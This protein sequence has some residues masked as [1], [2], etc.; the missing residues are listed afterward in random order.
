MLKNYSLPRIIANISLYNDMITY[1]IGFI[2][3]IY[4]FVLSVASSLTCFKGTQWEGHSKHPTSS[5]GYTCDA[6][7]DR[8]W[9]TEVT[10]SS[11]KKVT[12]TGCM[13]ATE[14]DANKQIDNSCKTVGDEKSCI[15]K[16]NDCNDPCES[17]SV[18]TLTVFCL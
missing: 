18:N 2:F 11:G 5:K 14:I 17:S 4:F 6:V 15:C 16:D 13:K 1:L 10:V 9:K 3:Y 8:C 7:D 12:V